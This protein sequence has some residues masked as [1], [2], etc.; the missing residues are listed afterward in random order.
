MKIIRKMKMKISLMLR[1]GNIIYQCR[2]HIHFMVLTSEKHRLCNGNKIWL[3]VR[4]F[5][6]RCFTGD[7]RHLVNNDHIVLECVNKIE[8]KAKCC[9]ISLWSDI[10][11]LLKCSW[12]QRLLGL[13]PDSPRGQ[14]TLHVK[15]II[16][17][18]LVTPGVPW[19]LHPGRRAEQPGERHRTTPL[20]CCYCQHN[21]QGHII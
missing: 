17:D 6:P 14:R 21:K 18:N 1:I 9:H 16:Q 2:S 12:G 15:L 5:L 13:L 4:V 7:C 19:L 8:F 20:H 10:S 3:S 11:A